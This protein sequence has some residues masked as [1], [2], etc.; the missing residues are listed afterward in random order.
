MQADVAGE[1]PR[2]QSQLGEHLE[3]VADAQNRAALAGEAA[4]FLQHRRKA[5]NGA[6]TQIVAI[7]EAT[8]Q[9]HGLQSLEI[10]LFVPEET[11]WH[12]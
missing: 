8:G 9:D 11:G 3:A 2:Q 5:S 6:A 1:G 7:T 4:D 10:P 12:P